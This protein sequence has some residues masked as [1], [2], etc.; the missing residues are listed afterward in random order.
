MIRQVLQPKFDVAEPIGWLSVDVAR[1]AERFSLQFERYHESGLG[2]GRACVV[3][4][5]SGRS[6][7]LDARDYHQELHGLHVEVIAEG[8]DIIDF[9]VDALLDELLSSLSLSPQQIIGRNYHAYEVAVRLVE[10]QK[11]KSTIHRD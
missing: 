8:Q 10:W 9:G 3:Q 11:S 6:F 5:D 4:T 2:G 1:V 7:G